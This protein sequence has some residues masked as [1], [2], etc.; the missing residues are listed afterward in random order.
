MFSSY[1]NIV[2]EFRWQKYEKDLKNK[3]PFFDY[4]GSSQG[5][6]DKIK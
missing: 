3:Q 5:K 1:Q 2:L 6:L 4:F